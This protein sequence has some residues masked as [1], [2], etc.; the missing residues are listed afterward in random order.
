MNRSRR[1][2]EVMAED[3]LA[4]DRVFEV[5]AERDWELLHEIADYIQKDIDPRMA[6]TDPARFRL[7]RDAVTRCHIKGLTYMTP[8]GIREATGFRPMESRP[9]PRTQDDSCEP[10]F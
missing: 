1:D 3:A 9:R 5:M 4:R 8:E 7:L 6:R 10:G 2:L